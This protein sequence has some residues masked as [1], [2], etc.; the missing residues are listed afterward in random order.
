MGPWG[1]TVAYPCIRWFAQVYLDRPDGQREKV[2]VRE[3]DSILCRDNRATPPDRRRKVV[4]AAARVR[5]VQ[6]VG[7]CQ[8]KSLQPQPVGVK[9][10]KF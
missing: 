8:T 6:M 10:M 2:D 7:G 9:A 5:E 4:I 3:A 1:L